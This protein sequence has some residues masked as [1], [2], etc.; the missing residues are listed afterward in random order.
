MYKSRL[1]PL[2][3]FFSLSFSLFLIFFPLSFPLSRCH[4]H[5]EGGT[6][7]LELPGLRDGMGH[8]G[9]SGA[10][11]ARST[12]NW[13]TGPLAR[14]FARSF[15]RSHRSFI[16][17]LCT[18]CFARAVRCAHL[19]ACTAHFARS[20]ARGTVN[21]KM[22]ILSVFFFWPTVRWWNGIWWNLR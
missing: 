8:S 4:Y 17:M 5:R 3:I 19:F 20:L 13:S 10:Q 6:E 12:K 21:D 18:I 22:A 11:W 16:C 2:S 14:P 7:R 1:A 9:T 15:V